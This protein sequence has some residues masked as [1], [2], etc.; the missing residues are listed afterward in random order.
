MR[1][2]E[3]PL[4]IELNLKQLVEDLLGLNQY[5]AR[6]VVRLEA[7]IFGEACTEC[8]VSG[9]EGS[10]FAALRVG[11]P[12]GQEGL[13]QTF[14][15]FSCIVELFVS[16]LT[17][18]GGRAWGCLI[19]G[20]LRQRFSIILKLVDLGSGFSLVL[21]W[22]GF[23]IILSGFFHLIWGERMMVPVL[24]YFLC[25]PILGLMGPV[26]N[27]AHVSLV[28]HDGTSRAVCFGPLDGHGILSY[29][30]GFTLVARDLQ[31]FEKFVSRKLPP[32]LQARHGNVLS[33]AYSFAESVEPQVV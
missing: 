10:R 6:Y 9:A 29:S 20:Q 30:V 19:I 17:W 23:S 18:C 7:Q 26:L 11:T 25:Y 13:C 28:E 3:G 24:F 22:I 16:P 4:R 8:T 2:P 12:V 5:S 14:E 21:N 1:L 15:T 27:C 33:P 32:R 31:V